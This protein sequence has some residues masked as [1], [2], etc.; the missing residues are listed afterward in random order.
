MKKM[1]GVSC[2]QCIII[3][4]R[5]RKRWGTILRM[6]NAEGEINVKR[7]GRVGSFNRKRKCFKRKK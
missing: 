5:L 4:A 3:V 7:C 1:S 6:K 2:G